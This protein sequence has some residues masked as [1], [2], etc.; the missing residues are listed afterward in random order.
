MDILPTDRTIQNA[1]GDFGFAVLE[2][3]GETP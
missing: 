1:A 2:C 3:I